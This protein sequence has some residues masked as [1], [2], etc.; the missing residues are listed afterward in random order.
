MICQRPDGKF[1]KTWL[2]KFRPAI[3]T[4]LICSNLIAS[5]NEDEDNLPER[6]TKL[7]AIGVSA[8]P[9]AVTAPAPGATTQVELTAFAATPKG[10]TVNASTFLDEASMYATPIAAAIS[11]DS[12]ALEAK[13]ALDIYSV[14]ATATI[15]P[16]NER[17]I[18][19]LA[20]PGG[21]LVFRY[22]IRL[23]SG[24]E[25]EDIVGNIVAYAPGSAALNYQALAV[26][27]SEPTLDATLGTGEGQ[28]LIGDVVKPQSENIKL[29]WFV[30]SGKVKNRRARDTKWEPVDTGQQTV[31]LTARGLVSGS[32]AMKAIDV[33]IE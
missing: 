26:N 21:K 8:S 12:E 22:G 23:K 18:A 30:S 33:K 25:S 7:R 15:G 6:I 16:L 32:F 13:A 24:E 17:Q 4:A 11:V 19:Q 5:C 10:Q 29:S 2:L 9:L 20:I 1:S 3:L 14:K 28:P 31:I 27:I